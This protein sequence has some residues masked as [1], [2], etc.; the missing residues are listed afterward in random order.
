MHTFSAV[1]IISH[2]YLNTNHSNGVEGRSI[3]TPGCGLPKNVSD[4]L[5]YRE[6]QDY[7]KMREIVIK[8]RFRLWKIFIIEK[9]YGYCLRTYQPFS[10]FQHFPG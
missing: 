6:H 4:V 5:S 10:F 9:K 1:F 8:S 7:P 3:E 2:Y